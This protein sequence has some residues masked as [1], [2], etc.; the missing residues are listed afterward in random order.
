ME[1]SAVELDGFGRTRDV[2]LDIA[3]GRPDPVSYNAR[4]EHIANE[5][6]FVAVPREERWTGT[7][8]P[9]HLSKAL[10][11]VGGY[12]DLVLQDAGRPRHADN[13]GFF[14]LPKADGKVRR[15]LSEVAG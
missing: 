5:L 7:A 15:I 10:H 12:F 2:A 13:V 14:G 1:R 9:V 4:S 3:S 8:A 11:L 6:V